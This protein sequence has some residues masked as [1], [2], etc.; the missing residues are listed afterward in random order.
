MEIVEKLRE[1]GHNVFPLDK[2]KNPK[3]QEGIKSWYNYQGSLK[4][5]DAF[6]FGMEM[7]GNVEAIDIDLKYD[8]TGELF[9]KF[10][11]R[12]KE[13]CPDFLNKIT[14]QKTKNNGY[15]FI[16]RCSEKS[17]NLKLANRPTTLEEREESFKKTLDK[18]LSKGLAINE[19]IIKAEKSKEGDKIRVLLETRG[20]GGYIAIYPTEGYSV[21]KGSL[22]DIKEV[23]VEE[24]NAVFGIAREF[25]EIPK[26]EFKPK[27]QPK[28]SSKGVSPFEDYNDRGDVVSLLESA[29]WSVVYQQ[30]NKAFLKR[31]GAS[32]AKTSGNYDYEKKWFSVFS[33]STEF[34]SQKA[35]LPYAVFSI[36]ECGGD[37]SEASRKLYDLGYGERFENKIE[38]EVSSK[39]SLLDDDISFVANDK[40]LTD[41][42]TQVRDGSF[43]MG[44]STGIKHL[45]KHFLFKSG[46][47]VVVNGHDNVGKSTVIWYLAL[48]SA[49]FHGWKWIIYSSENRTGGVFRRLMEFYYGKEL[50]KMNDLQY[51]EAYQFCMKYFKV[52]KTEELLNYKDVLNMGTKLLA[53]DDYKGF[54]IDPYNSLTIELNDR[55][56]LSTHEYHYQAASEM[57]L[58]GR[59]N[60]CCVYLNCHAVTA[61]LRDKTAGGDPKAPNKA[62]TE[63]GGKFANKADDF[64]TLHRLTQHVDDWMITQIHVRKIKETE[65]GG[66]P[67]PYESPVKLSML[68]HGTGFVCLE[69]GT[70][71]VEEYHKIKN[72][73]ITL[74]PQPSNQFPGLTPNTSFDSP[75]IEEECPF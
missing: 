63:G 55:S 36:L 1:N 39:I 15:H 29:G 68:P 6:G 49:M 22:L 70:N 14:V 50:S 10:V 40:E 43:E 72:G 56:K 5:E 9:I 34:D 11:D 65:T 51:N 4:V 61:A 37:Y 58:W 71:P 47:F 41:Y 23:T 33:T 74:E 52:I 35:Y 62:D 64:I 19:A 31:P 8:R 26:P 73:Q 59:K 13:V 16:Y 67:T 38:Q 69:D 24:R 20:N 3:L 46:N 21:K 18:E 57:K 54:L 48:L 7:N 66:K 25:D 42:L 12:I 53:K 32:D 30:R 45:D 60:D 2:T 44:K 17:G 28:K 75:I 27:V